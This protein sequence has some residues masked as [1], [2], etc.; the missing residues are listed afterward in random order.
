MIK[1]A[2]KA[3]DEAVG[4]LILQE[5][6]G[7]SAEQQDAL[8][9]WLCKSTLHRVTYLR[10]REGWRAAD[11][12]ASLGLDT[13][14]SELT[15]PLGRR[16]WIVAAIA[17]SLVVGVSFGTIFWVKQQPTAPLQ[18]ATQRYETRIGGRATVPLPDGSKVEMNT[19]TAV[20]TS[21]SAKRRE[22]WLDRGEAYFE[23]AHHD[24]LPFI[25]HAGSRTVTVLGTKFSARRAEGYGLGHRG[26]RSGR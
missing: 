3:S 14:P 8:D 26:P 13:R 12:I 11:R 18:I 24:G 16:R 22:I 6:P 10:Q 21:V 1:R 15:A 9:R 25:V 4:W 7:W 5:E 19:A 23:V 20:R 17:A 2:D